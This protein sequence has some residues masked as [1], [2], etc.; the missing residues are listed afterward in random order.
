MCV[1]SMPWN[2]L[3]NKKEGTTDSWHKSDEY[4]GTYA[5]MGVVIK[6][7]SDTSAWGWKCS[8]T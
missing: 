3:N 2:I 8:V 6:V 1:T 4:P 7:Q 5:E